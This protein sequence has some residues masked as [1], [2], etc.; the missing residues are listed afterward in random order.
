MVA[1]WPVS[2]NIWTLKGG[3]RKKL[4]SDEAPAEEDAIQPVLGRV[5]VPGGI[6]QSCGAE[7]TL[8]DGPRLTQRD[9]C[10]Y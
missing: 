6:R 9:R 4:T 8:V 7:G 1:A 5:H 2:I 3:T 10:C